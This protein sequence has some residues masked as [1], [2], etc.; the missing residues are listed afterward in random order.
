MKKFLLLT[1]L[2]ST[3]VQAKLIDKVAGVINDQIYTLSEIER[4]QKTIQIRKEIAPFIYTKNNYSEKDILKV[5]QNSFIIKDK[6]EE[7]GFII[8][9]DSVEDRVNETQKN[10]NL[11]RKELLQF[12]ASKNITYSEYF[13]I[14]REAME[15]NVFNRRIIA[16]LVT[17]TDQELKN[18]YYKSN[19]NNKVLSFKYEIVDY[20]ITSSRVQPNDIK[21]LPE[22]L[23]N[24]RK[25]GSL[26]EIYK[27][28]SMDDLGKV[29]DEDLPKNIRLVLKTTEEESFSEPLLIDNTLHVFYVVKKSLVESKDYLRVRNAIYN[30]LFLVR[31][32]DLSANWFSRE[33]L[34]YYILDNL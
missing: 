29:S 11:N 4:V 24:Y 9:D 26:P 25:T 34:N 32:N 14:L 33:A 7:L 16:P 15:F 12:L 5:L 8:S 17:I 2:F 19:M 30:R 13:E 6:L 1:L 10:L 3:L 31:A 23:N 18:E 20:T 27:D 22:V 21:A 28:F